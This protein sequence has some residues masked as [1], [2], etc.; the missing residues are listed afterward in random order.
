M[1]GES[2]AEPNGFDLNPPDFVIAGAPR[3]GTTSLYSYLQQQPG[4]RMSRKKE[5]AHFHF[6]YPRPDFE[7]LAQI[8]GNKHLGESITHYERTMRNAVLDP[9]LYDELW[10]DSSGLRGEA[11]PTYLFDSNALEILRRESPQTKL[12]LLL[13]NPVDRAYSQYLQYRRNGFEEYPTFEEALSHEP[14]DIDT[15]WWGKRRYLRLGLYARP[16]EN[17]LRLFGGNVAILFHEEMQNAPSALVAR[18]LSFLEV[19]PLSEVDTSDRHNTAFV[20]SDSS[21]VRLVQSGG[22]LRSLVSKFLPQGSRRRLYHYIMQHNARTPPPCE[23]ETR[24]RLRQFFE[25]DIRQLERL[26][27]RDL[28]L[29]TEEDESGNKEAG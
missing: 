4:I 13:R 18:V 27:N 23:L 16:V 15:F 8:H 7:R 29:W 22:V 10:P 12:I 19:D 20:P 14:A 9:I 2:E 24:R 21:I 26:V 11:T 6:A 3:C 17:C 28:S 5:P 1:V 25:A